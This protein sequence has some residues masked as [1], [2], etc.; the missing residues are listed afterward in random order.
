LLYANYG[1]GKWRR[2]HIMVDQSTRSVIKGFVT[3]NEIDLGP[4]AVVNVRI[5]DNTLR[6][7]SWSCFTEKDIERHER[8]DQDGPQTL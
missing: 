7:G 8:C 1:D 2:N 3:Q 4:C 5:T 6:I